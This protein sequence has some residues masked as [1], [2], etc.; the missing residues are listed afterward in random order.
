MR[1]N[2]SDNAERQTIV[3]GAMGFPGKDAGDVLDAFIRSLGMPRRLA[4][5]GVKP[6]NFEVIAE[7]AMHTPWVPRNPRK[8]DSPA[9]ILEILRL[10]A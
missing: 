6:E 7:Q 2:A 3:A 4:D 8:I 1:W 5:L 9:Q 10:A